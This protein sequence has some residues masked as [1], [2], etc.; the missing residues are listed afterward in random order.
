MQAAADASPG[1][2]AAVL[3]LGLSE[4]ASACGEV[5]GAWVANDNAP[6]QIVIAGTFEGVEKAGAAALARGA[7]RVL[8]L[9]VGGAFPH[10][11]DE[12]SPSAARRSG[13]RVGFSPPGCPVV[14]NVDAQPHL[15]GFRRA[16]R[17]PALLAGAL[18]GVARLRWPRLGPRLF[19]ELGPGTELSGHGPGARSPTAARANVAAP[20]DLSSL[21]DRVAAGLDTGPCQRPTSPEASLRGRSAAP[22]RPGRAATCRGR[23]LQRLRR[24]GAG[25]RPLAGVV[26]GSAGKKRPP[27]SDK[28]FG[29]PCEEP[30]KA[31]R[32][33]HVV[34]DGRAVQERSP[35]RTGARNSRPQRLQG[36]RLRPGQLV[37]RTRLASFSP[38]PRSAPGDP[39]PSLGARRE[40]ISAGRSCSQRLAAGK[41]LEGLTRSLARTGT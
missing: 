18:A 15:A 27:V 36:A 39:N 28:W 32:P 1:T 12:L 22:S 11:L 37:R 5:R 14:A 23:E 17:R 19:V 9:K 6:G 13:P 4:V 25:D 7:K 10:A 20:D 38:N 33:L 29:R 41:R 16:A 34:Y 21:A 3:G 24:H 8:P 2:M 40:R 31:E 30:P 35:A 26:V